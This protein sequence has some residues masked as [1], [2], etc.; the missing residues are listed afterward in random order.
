MVLMYM[1]VW[2]SSAHAFFGSRA[3]AQR[4]PIPESHARTRKSFGPAKHTHG[5]GWGWGGVG[6]GGIIASMVLRTHRHCNLIIS[7]SVWGGV[8]WGGIIASMVLRTHRHCNYII[9]PIHQS[10]PAFPRLPGDASCAAPA[11]Q[12]AP[13]V[14]QVLRMPRKRQ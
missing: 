7:P 1:A 11:T 13:E 3:H 8:G 14:L 12:N 9:S 5:A 4:P 6:W 2:A 10:S